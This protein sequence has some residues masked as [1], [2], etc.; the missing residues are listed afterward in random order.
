MSALIGPPNASDAVP[1]RPWSSVRLMVTTTW[2]RSPPSVGRSP[3]C[4]DRWARSTRASASRWG[5]V[6][7]SISV[8]VAGRGAASG[9]RADHLDVSGADRVLSHGRRRGGEFRCTDVPLSPALGSRSVAAA[10]RA[11]ASP[12]GTRATARSSSVVVVYPNPLAMPRESISATTDSICAQVECNRV[13]NA[14]SSATNAASLH[15]HIGRLAGE[16]TAAVD[17]PLFYNEA[18]TNSVET[19]EPRRRSRDK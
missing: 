10:I 1:I 9:L 19:S 2:G 13:S 7:R 5:A 18:L 17:M 11:R 6:R 8:S 15:C 4:S 12:S 3:A 16:Y 14:P